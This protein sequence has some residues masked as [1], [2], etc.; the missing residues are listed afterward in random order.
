MKPAKSSVKRFLADIQ[1]TIRR[2]K[3]VKAETLIRL[4]NPKIRGWTN[5]YRHVC[6]KHTFSYVDHRIFLSIWRWV[7]RR[8]PNKS[9]GWMKGKYFRHSG[10]RDWVFS[11][12]IKNRD[13]QTVTLDM[14]LASKTPIVRHIKIRAEATP[15]DPAHQEYLDGRIAKRKRGK[16][17][18][19]RW[20]VWP[21]WWGS[22][23]CEVEDS[24]EVGLLTGSFIKA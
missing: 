3:A 8:H 2:N 11:T 23:Y 15:Y 1:E 17:T 4:L 14:V 12:N 24:L 6:S 10:S 21:A 19:R 16:K 9:K 13:S 7:V 20:K 18:R 5:Y 22:H